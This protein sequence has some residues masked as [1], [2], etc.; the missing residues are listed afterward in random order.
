MLE[1]IRRPCT[2]YRAL[3]I[4]DLKDQQL[5]FYFNESNSVACLPNNP[6]LDE[7]KLCMNRLNE[8]FK[9]PEQ[10]CQSCNKS[11]MGIRLVSPRTSYRNGH[12]GL[13]NFLKL[14]SYC[15]YSKTIVISFEHL[16]KLC[17]FTKFGGCSSKIEPATPVLILNFSRAWQ[18][19]FES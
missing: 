16:H 6:I 17:L 5:H 2:I 10:L 13:L 19:F 18:S 7:S 8:N 11:Y 12:E 1:T 4:K 9:L 14:L 15:R 3:G